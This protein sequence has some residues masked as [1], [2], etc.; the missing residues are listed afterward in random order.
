MMSLITLI[1]KKFGFVAGIMS[2][3]EQ[4]QQCQNSSEKF[5]FSSEFGHFLIQRTVQKYAP[6]PIHHY[7]LEESM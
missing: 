6:H 7:I 2:T 5:S 1:E 3:A 4:L